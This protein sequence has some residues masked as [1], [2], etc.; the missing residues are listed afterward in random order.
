[1]DNRTSDWRK[2]LEFLKVSRWDFKLGIGLIAIGVILVISS[3]I[4]IL[5]ETF[6]EAVLLV[7]NTFTDPTQREFLYDPDQLVAENYWGGDTKAD[8]G[9]QD[10]GFLGAVSIFGGV[11]FIAF[12]VISN[13]LLNMLGDRSE[14]GLVDRTGLFDVMGLA[15]KVGLVMVGMGVIFFVLSAVVTEVFGYRGG[16]LDRSL[17][18]PAAIETLLD[19]SRIIFVCGLSR[20]SSEVL[21]AATRCLVGPTG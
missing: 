11:A 3:R 16:G 12:H 17:S 10:L 9:S 15:D 13:L 19:M 21:N 6:Y 7:L 20:C 8:V 1:M 4:P 5:A 14:S 2:A 18:I